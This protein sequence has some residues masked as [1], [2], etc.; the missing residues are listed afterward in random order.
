M[1]TPD[2]YN[3]ILGVLIFVGLYF[4]IKYI[5]NTDLTDLYDGF[6]SS[7]VGSN[8]PLQMGQ[9]FHVDIKYQKDYN[10]GF[11]DGKSGRAMQLVH[12]PMSQEAQYY[13]KGHKDGNMSSYNNS[14]TT[15][16]A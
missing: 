9:Q 11:Q 7:G 5:L 10:S 2:S 1:K 12:N 4:F 6:A 8:L 13:R 16:S 15:G 14:L 3:I